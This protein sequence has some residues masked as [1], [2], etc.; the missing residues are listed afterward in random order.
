MVALCSCALGSRAFAEV[1]VFAA[2]SLM[3]SLK[4]IGAVYEAQY[5]QKP[6]FNFAASSTLA[7]QI[8]EGAPADV[9]FCADEAQMDRLDKKGLLAEGTRRA[10]LSNTLVIIVAAD[11]G[12]KVRSPDDLTR[13]AIHRIALGDPATVPA[14]V[15]ARKYLESQGLWAEIVPKIV[16]TENVRGALAAVEAGNAD[17][18]IV[19]RTDALV[20]HKVAIAYGVPLKQGPEIRYPLAL[21]RA[22]KNPEAGRRLIEFLE[23]RAAGKIFEQHGFV[24]IP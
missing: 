17:A 5:G 23:G 6:L 3:E 19:Y 8:L 7:R 11:H 9:F 14:G 1:T 24:V 21:I 10:R 15:Y 4:E 22:A 13:P 20:S 12:A 2:A 16:P 18:A